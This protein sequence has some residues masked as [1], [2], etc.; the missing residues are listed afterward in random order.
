MFVNET[1]HGV[2]IG[3]RTAM[4]GKILLAGLLLLELRIV[5]A[6]FELP[7]SFIENLATAKSLDT[8]RR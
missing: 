5:T 2:V 4:R 1:E 6:G 7:T 8:E 3:R